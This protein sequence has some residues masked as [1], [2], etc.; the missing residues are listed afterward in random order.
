MRRLWP[1]VVSIATVITLLG[2]SGTTEPLGSTDVDAARVHWLALRP[3]A[4]TF[5]VQPSSSWFAPSGYYRIQVSAGQVISA[6]NPDG[7]VVT[8]FALT[9]DGIWDQLLAARASNELNSARFDARGVPLESDM[10]EWAVDGGRRYSV[11]NFA[12]S[13]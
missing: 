2:C 12:V 4:Y 10:G 8:D 7:Q 3:Q 1:S 9:I 5:E 6:R 13:R 11:R